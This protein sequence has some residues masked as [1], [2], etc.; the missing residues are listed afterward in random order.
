MRKS[1]MSIVSILR[2][3]AMPM[4]TRGESPQQKPVSGDSGSGGFL[5]YVAL[6]FLT[7]D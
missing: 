3:V 7:F 2:M 6:Q 5:G 1:A 4:M